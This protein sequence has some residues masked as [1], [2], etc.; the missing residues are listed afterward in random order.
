MAILSV[1]LVQTGKNTARY[2]I[3]Y[4]L[5]FIINGPENV[6]NPN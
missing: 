6:I 1:T 2:A 5:K 4:D 3:F